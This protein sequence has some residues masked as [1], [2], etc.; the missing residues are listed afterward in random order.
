MTVTIQYVTRFHTAKTRRTPISTGVMAVISAHTSEKSATFFVTYQTTAPTKTT[1]MPIWRT[2]RERLLGL[3]GGS[4][5]TVSAA[6]SAVI[7]PRRAV[8]DAARRRIAPPAL[9]PAGRTRRSTPPF[10]SLD[11][12]GRRWQ[13]MISP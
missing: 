5:A 11:P 2:W 4:T 1:D 3:R 12:G 10:S 9:P 6:S 8:P 7:G 13:G